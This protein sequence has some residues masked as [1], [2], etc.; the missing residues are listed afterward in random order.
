MR[1]KARNHWLSQIP[2]AFSKYHW[3]SLN[4]IG[5]LTIG[6]CLK[7]YTFSNLIEASIDILSYI[8]VDLY[9]Y[10]TNLYIITNKLSLR[11]INIGS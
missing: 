8:R 2:L 4:T 3:L 1:V 9:K 5:F 6:F 7:H 10:K 11:I